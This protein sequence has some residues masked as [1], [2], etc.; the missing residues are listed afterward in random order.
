[1]HP[2]LEDLLA[3]RDGD[4]A[5]DVAAHLETCRECHAEVT[6][7]TA[8]QRELLALPALEPERDLLAAVVEATHRQRVNRRLAAAGL[9]A[10]CLALAF[11]MTTAVRGGIEAYREAKIAR[12]ARSLIAESQ[13][14]EGELG[15]V[16]DSRA[17]LSGRKA[18]TI[19]DIENRITAVDARLAS[20]GKGRPSQE[21]VQLWQERVHLLGALADVQSTRTSYVGL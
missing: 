6:R 17:L 10:A 8:M 13:R 9:A 20:I 14:I 16:G 19:A 18:S 7:L 2:L 11:T 21:A 3:F 5:A 1:M 12:E 15:V 4:A